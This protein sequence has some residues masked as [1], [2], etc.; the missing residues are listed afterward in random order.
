MVATSAGFVLW[1][2]QT[3]F[4]PDGV[5]WTASP[6]PSEATWVSGAFGVEGGLI[7]LSSTDAGG[8]VFHRVDARGGNAVQLD[9]GGLPD[10]SLSSASWMPGSTTTGMVLA[11]TPP[12]DPDDMLS[13]EVDGYRLTINSVNG[14][15]DVADVAT[16]ET[17][18]SAPLAPRSD[19]DEAPITV[20]EAGITVTDPETGDVLVVFS[21]EALDAAEREYFDGGGGEYTPDFWLIASL[22]GERFV[23]DDLDDADDGPM[24]VA[25][26]G[27]RL[28]V[29][30]G[31]SWLTYDLT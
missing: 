24:S 8:S 25:S 9:V 10:G 16:G 6:L 2:D 4:S 7:V 15:F 26:N 29:Q 19:D 17:V 21:S 3:W 31:R 18:V 27:S 1:T 14:I 11:A 5:A 13:L 12:V 22:D 20:D 23:V 30:A 28:L